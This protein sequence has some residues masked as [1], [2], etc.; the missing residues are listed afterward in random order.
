MSLCSKCS[1]SGYI[2]D[3]GQFVSFCDCKIGHEVRNRIWEQKLIEA[4]IL[5]DYWDLKF[6]DFIPQPHR[7]KHIDFVHSVE[8]YLKN[9]QHECENG[10][11][12]LIVGDAGV[13]KTLGVS[14]ILKEA[15]K[16]D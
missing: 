16:K 8:A 10:R 14:L 13:G 6:R 2:T 11:L 4:G 12:W 1:D 3:H 15:I 5:K 9:I 7:T